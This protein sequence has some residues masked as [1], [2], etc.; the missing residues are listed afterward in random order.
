MANCEAK[1]YKE[2]K[3][4]KFK[5][6][7]ILKEYKGKD[8]EGMSYQPL[9]NY[10]EEKMTKKGCFKVLCADFVTSESGTG[11]V[12]TAPGFGADDYNTCR[13][14]NII[15]PDDP[16][17]SVDDSGYFID[18]ITDY[19]GTYLKDADKLII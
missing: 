5:E 2:K 6:F 17:V 7:E 19:K 13:Q 3:D 1:N 16:C 12:H 8:L 15:D 18:T 14:Y 11:I 10:Y 9:F 4:L